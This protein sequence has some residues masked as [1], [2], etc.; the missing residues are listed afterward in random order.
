MTLTEFDNM[1]MSAGVSKKE[2]IYVFEDDEIFD[3]SS[4]SQVRKYNELI[5]T[6]ASD[7][8]AYTYLIPS[9]ANAKVICFG[10]IDGHMCVVI[11]GKEE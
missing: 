7:F 9:I 11:E 8:K 1:R 5:C 4:W 10:E 6:I 2:P 3:S